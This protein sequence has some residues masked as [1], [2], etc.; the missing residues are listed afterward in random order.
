MMPTVSSA[1]EQVIGVGVSAPHPWP[2]F[3][4][5]ADRMGRTPLIGPQ[6]AQIAWA[7]PDIEAD[8]SSPV[9]ANDGTVYV[10]SLSSRMFYAVDGQGHIKWSYQMSSGITASPAIAGDGTVYIAP[11]G[12]DLYAF[13]PDGTLK[14]T[15]DLERAGYNSSPAV[16]S[17]G[18]IYVGTDVYFYAV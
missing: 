5:E 15:F 8:A 4:G 10:G 3:K 14:W 13:E 7:N 9:I 17:D 11:E 6:T 1:K 18:T 16:T 2:L 12:G